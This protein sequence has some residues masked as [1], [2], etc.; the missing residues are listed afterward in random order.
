MDLIIGIVF[1]VVVYKLINRL[2]VGDLNKSTA[3]MEEHLRKTSGDDSIK[4][5]RY[6]FLDFFR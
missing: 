6:S 4:L 2:M 5:E 3:E 1:I